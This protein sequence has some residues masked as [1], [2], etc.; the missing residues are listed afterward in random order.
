[1]SDSLILVF[2][3]YPVSFNTDAL[4]LVP[5]YVSQGLIV[6]TLRGS[7]ATREN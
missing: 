7:K 5:Y 6:W 2:M 4:I 3:T 1:M